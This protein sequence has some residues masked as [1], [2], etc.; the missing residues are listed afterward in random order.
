M[1]SL[2]VSVCHLFSLENQPHFPVNL[3]VKE[4]A[5]GRAFILIVCWSLSSDSLWRV[6][7]DAHGPR[8]PNSTCHTAYGSGC[9]MVSLAFVL[10]GAVWSVSYMCCW[11]SETWADPVRV[12][13]SRVSMG[14]LGDPDLQR[15]PLH[16]SSS[17]RP[18]ESPASVPLVRKIE[19]LK[20][21]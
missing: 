8:Q 15:I 18:S 11:A 13:F 2:E 7:G 19:F 16:Y 6:S 17:F 1:G 3:C 21:L 20:E 4:C 5:A 9:G 10:C 14:E 12:Q